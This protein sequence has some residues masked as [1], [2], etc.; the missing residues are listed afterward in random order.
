MQLKSLNPLNLI[1][2]LFSVKLFNIIDLQ[3]SQNTFG[4]VTDR[5]KQD[6]IFKKCYY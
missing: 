6:G 1:L 4:G 3:K 5:L 2:R